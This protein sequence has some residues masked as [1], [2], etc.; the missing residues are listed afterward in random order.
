MLTKSAAEK[1][2][3]K[4]PINLRYLSTLIARK[5]QEFT[6]EWATTVDESFSLYTRTSTVNLILSWNNILAEMGW[7]FPSYLNLHKETKIALDPLLQSRWK[8]LRFVF[9][10]KQFLRGPQLMYAF[11]FT[12]EGI[13][14]SMRLLFWRHSKQ[15]FKFWRGHHLLKGKESIVDSIRFTYNKGFF[16]A[17]LPTLL[18]LLDFVMRSY[19][20]TDHLNVSLQTL[21]NAFEKAAILPKHLAPGYGVWNL[22]KEPESTILFPSVEQD[23]RLPGVFLS[24]FVEFGSSYYAFY[25]RANSDGVILNR[26]AIMH[27]ATEYWTPGN[28]VKLLTFFDLTL[29]LEKVMKI[30]IHGQEADQKGE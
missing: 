5:P 8:F 19:F 28:A 6:K 22:K 13:E 17:C 20:H 14:A 2:A 23:L 16:A 1:L 12:P 30:V 29:R 3:S 11:L 15:I 9:A 24:S 26:H 25:L 7:P 18:G 21:R 27:C 4:L 10:C